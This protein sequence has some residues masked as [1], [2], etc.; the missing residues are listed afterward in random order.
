MLPELARYVRSQLIPTGGLTEQAIKSGFWSGITNTLNRLIQL[1]KVGILAHLLL[2]S[3]F[4]L[5]GIGFLSLA[6]FKHFSQ[7]GIDAALIHHREDRVDN[8]LNTAWTMRIVRGLVI[9]GIVFLVAPSVASLFGEPRATPIIRALG[10]SP[11][12]LSFR[13]PGV[14]YFQKDLQY[15]KRFFQILSGTVVNFFIAVG[16]GVLFQNVWAL[17]LGSLAGNITSFLVSYLIHDYRPQVEF[18]AALAKEMI[19]YG[20][21]ILGSA[22]VLFL[23]NQGDDAFVGWLLGATS[24]G[25]YQMAYRFSNAPATEI[26]QV[27]SSVLFPAYSQIQNDAD[28]LQSGFY[29]T[30]KLTMYISFPAATGIAAVAPIFVRVF[31]GADWLP[32]IPIMQLLAAWGLLRSL[33]SVTGP[34]FQAVGRPD[35]VTKLQ[36]GQL[37]IIAL[38]IYPATNRFG[39]LGTSWAI[40]MSGV[41]FAVPVSSYLAVRMVNGSIS[42]FIRILFYPIF[43]STLMAGIIWVLQRSFTSGILFVD[44]I[45][46]VV[47]GVLIYL[48]FTIA[49]ISLFNYDIQREFQLIY[50]S[51]V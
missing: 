1:L 9:T 16:L 43:G 6:V 37:I 30:V 38:L 21:W 18:N 7:L 42:E 26:T 35:I 10:L 3:D 33:V 48:L 29:R 47:V 44:F 34:L 8:Y 46:L 40:V 4:G 15:H 22:S 5:I 28:K 2:P 17:V 51:F 36:F 49:A 24:L 41:A 23:L 12:I 27:I 25:F 20:K 31:L 19:N 39:L 45:S 11:L 50:E 32:I 13:N 14:M